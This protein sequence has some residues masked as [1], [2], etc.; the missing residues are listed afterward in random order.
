MNTD[1][2]EMRDTVGEVRAELGGSTWW[3]GAK[4]VAWALQ[5]QPGAPARWGR[6]VR[7]LAELRSQGQ[8]GMLEAWLFRSHEGLGTLLAFTVRSHRGW[9]DLIQVPSTPSGHRVDGRWKQE[10]R[11]TGPGRLDG[12]WGQEGSCH[13]GGGA[14]VPVWLKGR[15]SRIGEAS[16]HGMGKKPAMALSWAMLTEVWGRWVWEEAGESHVGLG[17]LSARGVSRR[18]VHSHVQAQRWG[19]GG[20]RASVMCLGPLLG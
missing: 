14:G 4:G 5:V 20:D 16:G 12:D 6:R 13:H 11:A 8:M 10:N 17:C 1:L 15:A 9:P 3:G 7:W 2:N 18:Q 19:W